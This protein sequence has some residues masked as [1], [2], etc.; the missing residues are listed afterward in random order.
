MYKVM[1]IA[2]LKIIPTMETK[3]PEKLT[4]N[5][6]K[7]ENNLI[8]YERFNQCFFYKIILGILNDYFSSA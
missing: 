8:I 6:N 5:M 4:E 1:N 2:P 3:H 7:S